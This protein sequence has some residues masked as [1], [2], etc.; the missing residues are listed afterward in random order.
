MRAGRR[1]PRGR[2][3]S[4]R[5]DGVRAAPT[6]SCCAGQSGRTRLEQAAEAVLV[7]DR[8]TQLLGL[9]RLGPGIGADDDEVGLLRHR[10]GGLAASADDGL[11]RLVTGEALERAG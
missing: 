10:A 4:R 3:R 2:A 1:T 8:Q 11:L 5:L 9:G 7:E 6:G